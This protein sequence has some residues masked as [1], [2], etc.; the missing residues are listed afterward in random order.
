MSQPSGPH[1]PLGLWPQECLQL[2]AMAATLGII[3]FL[4]GCGF[5]LQKSDTELMLSTRQLHHIYTTHRSQEYI[6]PRTRYLI[7]DVFNQCRSQR[8]IDKYFVISTLYLY[9]IIS[10]VRLDRESRGSQ[11][12]LSSHR[13]SRLVH[14]GEWLHIDKKQWRGISCQCAVD[15]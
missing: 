1:E 11:P 2:T 5:L 3:Q 13:V 9:A 7:Y 8:L 12:V 15:V 6:R 4:N 10:Q 14:T